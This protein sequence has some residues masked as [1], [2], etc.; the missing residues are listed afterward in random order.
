[1]RGS[2]YFGIVELRGLDCG[3]ALWITGFG[4][5]VS[6]MPLKFCLSLLLSG[7]CATGVALAADGIPKGVVELFTSQGCSQCPPA[8]AAL[9]KLIDQGDVV[10]LSYHVD[11]WN[12][13]GWTD[14]LSSKE[15]T[16]RQYGYAKSLGRSGVYTP[17]AVLNGRDHMNGADLTSINAR[18]DG[19]KASGQ[20]LKVPVVAAMKGDEIEID[21]G[22]GQGKADVVMVYFTKEQ[23]IKVAK[24]ENSG[25]DIDYRNSVTDVQTVGM[26]D[27]Q[28]MRLVLPAKV[29]GD[30]VKKGCAV[31]LQTSN[32]SGQPSSII[33]AAVLNGGSH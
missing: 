18:L 21:I 3:I 14:T 29:V 32:S 7:A 6:F 1:M 12:Y 27:G 13:L 11:Y 16:A 20:G 23:Q 2:G 22:A 17:Q 4:E 28:K 15:N 30:A 19:F 33:G 24:G 31:L 26:W 8:D 10:A 9:Q 5:W 25:R